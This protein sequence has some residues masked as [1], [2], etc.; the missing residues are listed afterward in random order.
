MH[1]WKW[2]RV[3]LEMALT[4]VGNGTDYGGNEID[5][6]KRHRPFMK[7]KLA[8]P[9]EKMRFF[10]ERT[11]LLLVGLTIWNA[12]GDCVAGIEPVYRDDRIRLLWDF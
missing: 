8:S 10:Y 5:C 7:G 12:N 9:S 4:T 2:H 1:S 3:R 6:Y 11:A